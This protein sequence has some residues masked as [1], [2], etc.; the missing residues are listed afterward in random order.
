MFFN[1]KSE[2]LVKKQISS[3]L[4]DIKEELDEHLISVNQNT[5][6]IQ[7]NYEYL[8]ELDSKISKLKERLDEINAFLGMS[9]PKSDYKISPLTKNEKEVF[10]VLY[11][12]GEE[13]DYLTYKEIGRSLA[14]SKELVMGYITNLIEKGIPLIKRYAENQIYIKLDPKFKKIQAKENIV[15][16]DEAISMKLSK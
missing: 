11:T 1:K 14:L 16:I 9:H 13:K 4:K 10:L 6:E 5:N 7:T 2:E 15:N 3:G 12:K 8:C